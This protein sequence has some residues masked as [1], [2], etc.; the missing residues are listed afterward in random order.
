MIKRL[1]KSSGYQNFFISGSKKF[2]QNFQ[3]FLIS[4]KANKTEFY[5]LFPLSS[6]S[7]VFLDNSLV[8][9]LKETN[10]STSEANSK[11]LYLSYLIKSFFKS[12]EL[13]FFKSCENNNCANQFELLVVKE[14]LKVKIAFISNE[15]TIID[16][17]YFTRT[18]EN[19]ITKVLLFIANGTE[20]STSQ[21][22]TV[23][24]TCYNGALYKIDKVNAMKSLKDSNMK[25]YQLV[26][27]IL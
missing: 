8:L 18:Q 26:V 20:E 21:R 12:S 17:K 11:F 3:N 27:V 7:S 24:T 16:S 19:Q 23:D 1:V 22:F 5:F 15:I 4:N 10:S 9:S 6:S 13:N 25:L 14:S 2:L